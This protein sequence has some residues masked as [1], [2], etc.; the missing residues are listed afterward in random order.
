MINKKRA[1][2]LSFTFKNDFFNDMK[3][4]KEASSLNLTPKV[5]RN[6]NRK[7]NIKST[8]FQNKS[9]STNDFEASRFSRNDVSTNISE[10]KR[11]D[12]SYVSKLD[13]SD[14]SCN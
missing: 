12:C 8:L 4:E 2:N 11:N 10:A 1:K 7:Y 14:K 6:A 13:E 5:N 3:S 9:E